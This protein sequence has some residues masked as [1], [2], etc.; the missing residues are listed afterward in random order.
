M[1][2]HLTIVALVCTGALALA[3]SDDT[4][5]NEP[6]LDGGAAAVVPLCYRTC[7]TVDDCCAKPPCD[8]GGS[9]YA[10]EKGFCKN[11]GC[12]S[13]ADC[14][15][16]GSSTGTCEFNTSGIQ[17]A[18]AKWCEKDTECNKPYTCS[19]KVFSYAKPMCGFG[20]TKDIKCP[21]TLTCVDNKYCMAK[22]LTPD[23]CTSDAQCPAAIAQTKCDQASS[24]CMCE[25]D[26]KCQDAYKATGGTYKCVKY[27]W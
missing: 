13:D 3:C 26:Q 12:K 9:F 4:E 19:M 5:F 1:K 17:G 11:V 20:C 24:K 6:K 2:K 22:S 8:K 21:S 25:T 10:C 15:L 18:C 16:A 27:P 23:K 14:V 7:K